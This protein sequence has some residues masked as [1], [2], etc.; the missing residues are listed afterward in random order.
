MMYVGVQRASRRRPNFGLG[1]IFRPTAHVDENWVS[2]PIS[3]RG[4]SRLPYCVA[5]RPP[6]M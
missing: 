3:P 2:P 4:V 6:R 5:P 1:N